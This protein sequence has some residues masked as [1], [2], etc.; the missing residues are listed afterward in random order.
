[1]PPPPPRAVFPS[2]IPL[3][4]NS[5]GGP[6]AIS[7]SHY[8]RAIVQQHIADAQRN[9]QWMH[10]P[11]DCHLWYIF[12]YFWYRTGTSDCAGWS[13]CD[14]DANSPISLWY[15][16]SS[17][18]L[19]YR[20]WTFDFHTFQLSEFKFFEISFKH[21]ADTFSCIHFD[22]IG[23]GTNQS[24]VSRGSLILQWDKRTLRPN[25]PA[26]QYQLSMVRH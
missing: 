26:L 18:K 17:R 9:G 25:H 21:W 6:G 3:E 5:S 10:L 24:R 8:H 22:I 20:S 2:A 1:M 11:A 12:P 19:C 4:A 23:T 13:T 16:C 15:F 7:Q 14:R